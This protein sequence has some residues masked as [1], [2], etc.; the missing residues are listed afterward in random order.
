M[1]A[2]IVGELL[3]I[4]RFTFHPGMV[5]EFKR[6][7]DEC[8]EIVKTKDP[9]TLQYE[10]YLNDDE[11]QAM[12]IE[13]YRDS[14]ALIEHLANI[15]DELMQAIAATGDVYGETL[16]DPSPE[17]REKMTGAPVQLFTPFRSL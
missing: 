2:D 11:S 1:E 4:A 10:I 5:E 3:G 8:M 17:L 12:V 6:L 7:S 13:R 9:G 16:G 14:D 15:G